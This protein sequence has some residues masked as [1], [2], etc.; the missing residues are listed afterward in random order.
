MLRWRYPDEPRPFKA[1]GYPW[2]PGLFALASVA[3]VVNAVVGDPVPTLTG[4]GLM[5]AGIPLFWIM[6][7]TTHPQAPNGNRE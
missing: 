1:W 7:R 6:R 2:A 3:I 4:L 5:A